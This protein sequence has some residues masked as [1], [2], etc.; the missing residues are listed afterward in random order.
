[1]ANELA[2]LRRL[3][4]HKMGFRIAIA[5]ATIGIIYGYDLGAIAGARVFITKDLD[6]STKVTVW[7][8][9]NVVGGM[10]VGGR[11]GGRRALQ[12]TSHPARVL[13]GRH[14]ACVWPV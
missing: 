2:G 6:L 1:M 10:F 4:T 14:V 12:S 11:T 9:T 5:A 13:V 3:T 8:T 7:V